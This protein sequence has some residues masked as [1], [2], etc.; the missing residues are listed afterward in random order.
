[1]SEVLSFALKHAACDQAGG[2]SRGEEV[3]MDGL[4]DRS[5]Q[6]GVFMAIAGIDGTKG[7]VAGVEQDV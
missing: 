3:I 1:M 7:S 5:E 4:G 2:F 6:F